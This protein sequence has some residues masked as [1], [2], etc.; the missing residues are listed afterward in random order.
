MISQKFPLFLLIFALLLGGFADTSFE[1]NRLS[2]KVTMPD[3][4]TSIKK[5][6]NL[7]YCEEDPPTPKRLKLDE[8]NQAN[9]Q[10]IVSMHPLDFTAAVTPTENAVLNQQEKTFV[11]RVLPITKGSKIY[12]L[13]N[14]VEV[15]NVF[16][17]TPKAIFNIGRRKPGNSVGQVIER[18]G[19]IDIRC[20]IHCGM[21][22]VVLS[23]ET[24][25]FA[26]IDKDGNYSIDGLP[27]GRYRLEV[28]HL[29]WGNYEETI[30]VK[31]GGISYKNVNLSR[32]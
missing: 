14:D 17:R 5:G 24:P 6:N 11:P 22:A 4:G 21:R 25:Y 7:K 27:D 15:H 13:N 10:V 32:P 23:L 26:K 1:K 31:G 8:E 2:G 12:I 18:S 29:N 16:S 9:K 3:A 19:A 28:Y 30:T 20:D